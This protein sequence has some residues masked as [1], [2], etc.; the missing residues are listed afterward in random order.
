MNSFKELLRLAR[1]L[2]ISVMYWGYRE[3]HYDKDD[4]ETSYLFLY[5]EILI[6]QG[7]L[8]KQVIMPSKRLLIGNYVVSNLTLR[9]HYR[10]GGYL[11]FARYHIRSRQIVKNNLDFK[12]FY[13]KLNVSET[14][15]EPAFKLNF[16]LRKGEKFVFKFYIT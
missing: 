9:R 4:K 16:S 6:N 11:E 5:S 1:K 13:Y 12:L 7:L 15:I 8:K 2:P 3:I 10:R 14:S